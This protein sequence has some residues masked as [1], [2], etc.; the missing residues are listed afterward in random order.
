MADNLNI[1]IKYT[2]ASGTG[3]YLHTGSGT[4]FTYDEWLLIEPSQRFYFSD[5]EAVERVLAGQLL[6][7]LNGVDVLAASDGVAELTFSKKN[8]F[9]YKYIGTDT[10]ISVP[11][12][13][14]MIVFE[15][16]L[17]DSNGELNIAGE[18]V[19]IKP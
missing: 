11:G 4:L 19:F 3:T 7:S 8:N 14:Q 12:E 10:T 13:Q 18:V 2:V 6:V 17:I 1:Y 5:G 15:D 16:L 9:S